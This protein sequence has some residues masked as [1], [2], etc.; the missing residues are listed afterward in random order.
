MN[1][2]TL[3]TIAFALGGI[4]TLQSASPAFA[5]NAATDPRQP[6][7]STPASTSSP[8]SQA[9]ASDADKASVI[10]RL[11]CV[12]QRTRSECACG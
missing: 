5:Q 2:R 8:A 9:P 10:A 7:A 11:R 4:L 3:Q 6:V 1:P 12:G